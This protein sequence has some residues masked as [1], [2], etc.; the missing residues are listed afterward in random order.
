MLEKLAEDA[1]F[2]QPEEELFFSQYVRSQQPY[3]FRLRDRGGVDFLTF[4]GTHN[5]STAKLFVCKSSQIRTGIDLEMD[6]PTAQGENVI[7]ALKAYP[8]LLS[9]DI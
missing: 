6:R 7:I 8:I 9:S 1:G 2:K 3:Y 4:N 5:Y